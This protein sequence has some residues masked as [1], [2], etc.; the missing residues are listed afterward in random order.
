M[1][2]HKPENKGT[3]GLL[4]RLAVREL[5]G[6][7][8]FAQIREA[9]VSGDAITAAAAAAQKIVSTCAQTELAALWK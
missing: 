2:V 1:P 8:S 9:L 7:T 4:G 6:Q 3:H 5:K